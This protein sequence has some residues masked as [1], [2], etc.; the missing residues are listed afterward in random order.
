MPINFLLSGHMRSGSPAW[1][2]EAQSK[3]V[4]SRY[5]SE[6]KENLKSHISMF[7]WYWIENAGRNL[8]KFL[9]NEFEFFPRA[10]TEQCKR[11]KSW[12]LPFCKSQLSSPSFLFRLYSYSKTWKHLICWFCVSSSVVDRLLLLIPA[13]ELSQCKILQ[14]GV[15]IRNFPFP[16]ET[17]PICFLIR[18]ILLLMWTGED[19]SW[20]LMALSALI[21]NADILAVNKVWTI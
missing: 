2:R 20:I 14:S 1:R 19:V 16:R 7:I 15:K 8:N 9:K 11:C 18:C 3:H 12:I 5:F 21:I 4:K 13:L 10:R 6:L 17:H